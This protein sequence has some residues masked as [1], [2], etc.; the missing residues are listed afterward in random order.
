VALKIDVDI[1]KAVLS[2][3]AAA[4]IKDASPKKKRK[5]VASQDSL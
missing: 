3:F 4:E 1:F 5:V 2:S